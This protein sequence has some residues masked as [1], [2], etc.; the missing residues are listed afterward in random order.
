MEVT[1]TFDILARLKALYPKDDILAGKKDGKWITYSTDDYIEFS[2]H[3]AY[4]FLEMG[5]Q[6][7]DKVITASH[8]CPQWNFIDMGLSLAGLIHVPIYTT[9][10]HEDYLH[11]IPHSDAKVIF[12]GG[13]SMVRKIVP[14]LKEI[15]NPPTVYTI[16]PVAGYQNVMDLKEI[17]ITQQSKWE[18]QVAHN[19]EHLDPETVSTIIYTSG[20]TGLP[21]GVMLS[22]R[23]LVFVFIGTAVQQVIDH[24]HKMLSFLPLCHIYERSM[25]YE[26]QYLGTSTYY[27]ENLGTISTDL[28]DIKADGFCSVPRVLE[29]MFHKLE[30]AG[31]DLHGISKKIY[32]WAFKLAQR[33]RY[34]GNPFF[35]TIQHYFADKLVYSKWRE[36]LGGNQM[37][38]VTGGSSIQP[39]IIRLFSA[40]KLYIYEGYGMT[41]AAPV[42]AVNNPKDR[43][44]KIGT[45]GKVMD[46][47]EVKIAEDGEIL[48]R[49]P[50]LM[51]GYY[52]D[53][54]YTKQVIDE[55]G[56]LHTGDV[57]E[58]VDTIFLKITDRKKEIFKLSAG[59][60]IAPQ[61]IEN[62]L[63]E[64]SYI[65][66]VMV[67]GENQKV[68]SAIIIP[69]FVQVRVWANGQKL[70]Y[71]NDNELIALPEV[72]RL[73][74]KEVEKINQQLALHEQIRKPRLAI[75][76]WSPQ[77]GF[78]SQT[79]KLKRSVLTKYYANLIQEIYKSEV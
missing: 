64:S 74:N 36:K 54:E 49:G 33:F 23:A 46:G 76:D 12:L 55:E 27:A 52:K 43:I 35:Y 78:L 60:Y 30:A 77:N 69:N 4:A 39:R 32:S 21:K 45:V 44:V 13:D 1:R 29:M 75:D 59:K 6:P 61:V 37:L 63:K 18:A 68:P 26:F 73:I 57:G 8:N 24:R 16:D 42:I 31:K 40:A 50:L 28:H 9:L 5:L 20:T 14:V 38:V 19:K 41:E 58:F 15:E 3:L 70:S 71:T 51:T 10:S 66:N 25:N 62:K 72:I 53:P 2:H 34:E 79:L 48:A 7:G 22:H 67:V 56:W 65:E 47:A 11:I 17:G